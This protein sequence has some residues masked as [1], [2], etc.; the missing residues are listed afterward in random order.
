MKRLV[1]A[2]IAAALFGALCWDARDRLAEAYPTLWM[3]R[4]EPLKYAGKQVWVYPCPVVTAKTGSFQ[5]QYDEDWVRI[6]S[7]LQ[8]AVGTRVKVIGTFLAD[9]SVLATSWVE[10]NAYRFKR[11]GVIVISILVLAAFAF[12]LRRTFAWRDGAIHPREPHSAAA[13]QKP[14]DRV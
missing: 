14:K 2:L 6:H 3:C 9:G 12:V 10:D 8:P 7:P 5:I 4:E 13:L 1:V 11:R